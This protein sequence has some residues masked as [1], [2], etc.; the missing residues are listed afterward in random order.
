MNLG[1]SNKNA[2]VTGGSHGLGLSIATMLATEGVNVAIC[3][4][5]K[6][7]LDKVISE[8]KQKGVKTLSITAD[9]T[10]KQDIDKV[11][12]KVI[13]TW[14]S[15]DILIN[16]VG[17][18]GRW[19]NE[20]VEKTSNDVW[21]D[22]YHKNTLSAIRFTMKVIPHMKKKGWGRVICIASI[23]GREGGGRPWFNLAKNSQISLMKTLAMDKNL[24]RHGITFN[25]VAPGGIMIPETGWEQEKLRNPKKFKEKIE[26]ELPL[27]RLGVPDEVASLVV[28]LCSKK[29]SLINGASIP[30]DGGQSSSF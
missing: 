1:L 6:G 29:S 10:K 22:V 12:S 16:N 5:K 30:V 7:R 24:A 21:E 11:V 25:S 15:I 14:G 27:G 3:A 2:L 20:I 4:R 8:I 13:R 28:F 26:K 9:V 18:G 19:G 17:G 23:Y